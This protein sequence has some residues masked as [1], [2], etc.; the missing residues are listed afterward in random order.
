M[1]LDHTAE[2]PGD[3][4]MVQHDLEERIR[5]QEVLCDLSRD[6]APQEVVS[7]KV[8][9][10][11]SWSRSPHAECVK[12]AIRD[13]LHLI[14]KSRNILLLRLLHRHSL[15]SSLLSTRRLSVSYVSGPHD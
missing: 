15:I 11:I 8:P 1:A 10:S 14:A 7:R 4:P 13:G 5:L 12:P 6:L 3:E 2:E 9:Q